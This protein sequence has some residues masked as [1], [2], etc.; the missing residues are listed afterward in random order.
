[1]SKQT[2]E[3]DYLTSLFGLIEAYE[4]IAANRMQKIR[5]DVLYVRDYMKGLN[6]IYQQVEYSYKNEMEMAKKA[7][8]DEKNGRTICVFVSANS[9][10]YGDLVHRVFSLFLDE[11]EKQ[12]GDL[13]II[14]AWGKNLFKQL[15]PKIEF[16]YFDFPDSSVE[17]TQVSKIAGFLRPYSR[18]LVYHGLFRNIIKQEVVVSNISGDQLSPEVLLVEQGRLIFEPSLK[19]LLDFFEK[20]IFAG[21]LNQTFYESHLAKFSARMT[22]LDIATQNIDK[23]KKEVTFQ[24]L[25]EKHRI[26]NK[27]QLGTVIGRMI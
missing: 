22:S 26:I 5:G 13:A 17:P 24:M 3:I 16:T 14:G 4:E 2:N 15:Y 27:K 12:N 11:R 21:L 7:V 19:T 9:G 8:K 20:E 23:A 18:V 6:S 1:M 25:R 10:M